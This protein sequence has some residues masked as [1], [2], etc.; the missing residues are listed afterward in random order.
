MPPSANNTGDDDPFKGI[1]PVDGTGIADLMLSAGDLFTFDDVPA[2]DGGEVDTQLRLGVDHGFKRTPTRRLFV[3]YRPHMAA[4][5]HLHDLPR[6]NETLHGVIAGKWALFELIPALIERTGQN[7]DELT[8]T[9]LSF[10]KQNAA[11]LLGLLEHG[12]VRSMAM[13]VSYYFK[14]TSRPIYDS[15]VPQ[16]RELGHRV[17]AM[18]N[19]SKLIL[20]KMADGT[21]Y[22]A[23]SSAN[24]RSSDNVESLVLTCSR[25]LYEFHHKWIHH[26]LLTRKDLG[27]D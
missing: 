6:E 22:V 3:D 24:L 26:E 9:T 21:C 8:L 23:E 5:T 10:S 4:Y 27:K 12:H 17:L 1:E 20:A 7:I 16:L 15:L 25:E 11:D 18:R 19:H 13:V 2:L 14:S